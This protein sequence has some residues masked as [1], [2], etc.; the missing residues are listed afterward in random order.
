ML[1]ALQPNAILL[2]DR[3]YDSNAI[4]VL[5]AERGAWGKHPA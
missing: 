1:N 2:A 4:R 3:A 5:A